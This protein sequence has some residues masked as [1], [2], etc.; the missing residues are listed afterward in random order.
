[1]LTLVI[2]AVLVIIFAFDSFGKNYAQ[3]YAQ[4]LLKTPV[5]I[6]QF[7]SDFL[8]RT[9]NIDFIEVQNPTN[10]KNKNALSIEHFSIKADEKSDDD[11]LIIDEL[12]FDGLEFILEQ[13]KTSV[14]LT[15]LLDNLNKTKAHNDD[16]TKNSHDEHDDMRVKIN[17]FI[18]N[19]VNLKVDT[20]W[21]KTT[22]KVPNISA[23]NF[24][25]HSGAKFNQIGVEILQEILQNIKK[26]LEKK[27]IEVGK[28]KIKETLIRKIGNKINIDNLQE[29]IDLNNIKN[30]INTGSKQIKDTIEKK[31]KD[32]FDDNLKEKAQDLLKG[33][34]F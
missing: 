22:I 18:V 23:S 15:S 12:K 1:M 32:T 27:G 14:N 2:V 4:T 21:L 7:K 9:L 34:K 8:E 11:L 6:S 16:N 31:I 10:F 26:S 33:L 28:K 20:D 17:K 24:G 13:D 5:T 25:G 19:N 30:N 29:K 3:K